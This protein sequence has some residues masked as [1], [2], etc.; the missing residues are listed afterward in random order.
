MTLDNILLNDVFLHSSYN[1]NINSPLTPVTRMVRNCDK[2]SNVNI[3]N[4][5]I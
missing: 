2:K 3:V 5:L 1:S 4:Q